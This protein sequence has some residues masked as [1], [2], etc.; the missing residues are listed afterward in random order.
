MTLGIEQQEAIDKILKWIASDKISFSLV[1]SAGTGK[2]FLLSQLL[3]KLECNYVLCAPTHKAAL[4]MRNSCNSEAITLHSLLA[5]TPNLNIEKFDITKL[6]F[7]VTRKPNQIPS[8]GLVI[9]DEASMINDDLFDL[10]I[11]KCKEYKA[12][13]LFV[14]DK[15]QLLPV[16]STKYS[17]VYTNSDESYTLTK[18][19]R[20]SNENCLMPLLS[21]LRINELKNIENASS[22]EGK[23]V[24]FNDVKE[25]CIKCAELFK[26]AIDDDNIL[27]VKAC[28]FTNKR[29]QNY[30]LLI[31]KV[32]WNYD[33]KPFHIGEILTAYNNGTCG[34]IIK[35]GRETNVPFQYY[36]GMD[37]IIVDIAESTKRIPVM[38]ETVPGYELVLYDSYYEEHGKIFIITNKEIRDKVAAF[39]ENIRLKALS[40]K[41]LWKCYYQIRDSYCL[42]NYSYIE[43]RCIAKKDFDLGY[44]SSVH[45]LQ[46][47]TV[48]NICIDLPNILECKDR[49]V[50]RQLEYVAFSRTRHNAFVLTNV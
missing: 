17:K 22:P 28:A 39:Q 24:L 40:N 26:K 8:K 48:D 45:K 23:I 18:I 15:A 47:S 44:C 25:Y 13:I 29:V 10:M 31:Q 12:K 35:Y 4:V 37:Y 42:N 16:E 43:N 36:N 14:S 49:L 50:R 1:G 6:M 33:N 46:G 41:K 5:L 21:E 32:L 19:Y 11:S 34:K 38:E 2:T 3:P 9:C 27:Y 20:Q 30:N 7:E